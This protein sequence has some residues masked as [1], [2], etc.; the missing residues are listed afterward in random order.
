MRTHTRNEKAV[1]KKS[2]PHHLICRYELGLSRCIDKPRILIYPITTN[3]G[4]REA[5][6]E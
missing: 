4:V 6:A 1:L 5:Q 2:Q 3:K